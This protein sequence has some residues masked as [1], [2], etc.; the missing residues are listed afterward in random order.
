MRHPPKK[1]VHIVG[2]GPRT[3]TTLMME[4]MVHCYEFDAYANHEMSLLDV[5]NI[6]VDRFC[7][8][9]PSELKRAVKRLKRNP[10]LWVICMIRDPRDVVVSRHRRRPALY[11]SNLD[12]WKH[13]FHCF[14]KY[15]DLNRLV[16]IK[17]E[18]LVQNPD[19]VQTQIE[20]QIP[21]L[22]RLHRF[23][24][25]HEIATPVEQSVMALGGVRQISTNSI[26]NWRHHLPRLKAQIQNHG[27]VSPALFE[28]GYEVDDGWES[29][30]DGVESDN[31]INAFAEHRLIRLT[32]RPYRTLKWRLRRLLRRPYRR[33]IIAKA[34]QD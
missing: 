33:R 18:E 4:L 11:W 20:S 25:F 30:L 26:G 2:L 29:V 3:G 8:K 19:E 9:E 7:S 17:Y 22:R 34:S 24:R 23:S 15:Q 10:G 32:R 27:S 28:L 16:A 1:R 21:F 12:I 5:P 13:H 6:P 31:G 14:S